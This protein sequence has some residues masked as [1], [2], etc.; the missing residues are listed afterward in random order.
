[1]APDSFFECEPGYRL[2]IVLDQDQRFGDGAIETLR[3]DVPACPIEQLY[4][5]RF[6]TY[7]PLPF[8]KRM[9]R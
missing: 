7:V 3:P 2:R 4:P 9:N 6:V 1:M 8:A 5:L